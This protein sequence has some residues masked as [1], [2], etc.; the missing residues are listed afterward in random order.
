MSADCNAVLVVM[1]T[2]VFV[3][4][5]IKNYHRMAGLNSKHLFL[6]VLEAGNQRS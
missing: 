5:A 4:A 1:N 3:R 6:M 2:S